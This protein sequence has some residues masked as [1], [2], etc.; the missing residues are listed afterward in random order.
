MH[1][2]INSHANR[3]TNQLIV[4]SYPII[5]SSIRPKKVHGFGCNT[6]NICLKGPG[7]HQMVQGQFGKKDDDMLS[8]VLIVDYLTPSNDIF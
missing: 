1:A 8:H 4:T 7:K 5:I 3:H 2:F 6:E